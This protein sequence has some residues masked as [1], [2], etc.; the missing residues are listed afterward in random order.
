MIQYRKVY[1]PLCIKLPTKEWTSFNSNGD[2]NKTFK[3]LH[4]LIPNFVID[5]ES[6]TLCGVLP[7]LTQE[8]SY[9]YGY[10]LII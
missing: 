7:K 10:R 3:Y 9:R 6:S 8:L 5:F 4:G 2:T 1:D